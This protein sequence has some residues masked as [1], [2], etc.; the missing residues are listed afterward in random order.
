MIVWDEHE[1]PLVHLAAEMYDDGWLFD[2]I[3]QRLRVWSGWSRF[4][5]VNLF[6]EEAAHEPLH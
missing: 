1:E 4:V 5:I 3:D 2:C 6:L